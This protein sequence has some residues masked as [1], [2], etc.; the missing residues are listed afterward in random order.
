MRPKTENSAIPQSHSAVIGQGSV[1]LTPLE[2]GIS[3]IDS[4]T[5]PPPPQTD[6]ASIAR[7]H[8]ELAM[9]AP[10]CTFHHPDGRRCGSA[11]VSGDTLCYHHRARR[12]EAEAVR[13]LPEVTNGASFHRAL[14]QVLSDLYAGRLRARTAGQLL[15]GLQI[16]SL[17]SREAG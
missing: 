11:A 8:L 6:A 17:N 3:G 9:A 7:S 16:A 2:T 5:P 14:N 4:A 13:E 15:Y 1:A 10:R 12:A